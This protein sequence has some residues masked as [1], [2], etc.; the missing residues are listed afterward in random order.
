MVSLWNILFGLNIGG[1]AM[2]LAII[3]RSHGFFSCMKY[4][5]VLSSRPTSLRPHLKC[6][7]TSNANKQYRE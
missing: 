2:Q 7:F 1:A 5:R 6:L 4:V 3:L